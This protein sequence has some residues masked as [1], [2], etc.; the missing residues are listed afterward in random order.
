MIGMQN[1]SIKPQIK[2]RFLKSQRGASAVEFALVA[3]IFLMMMMSTFEV[4]WFYFVNSTLDTAITDISRKIR[5]GQVQGGPGFDKDDFFNDTVCPSLSFFGDCHQIAT[6]EVK[7]FNSFSELYDDENLSSGGD[8][9][10]CRGDDPEAVNNIP[11]D[12][13]TENSIVRVRLCIIYRTLNPA[14]GIN[15][16]QNANGERQL[17]S[18]FIFRNE[19][20][21]RNV[22]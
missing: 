20:F 21:L 8:P 19:P 13:G 9:I 15:L 1:A 14:V 10:I 5:T 12:P 4:G 22:N 7:V 17:T 6:A 11:V 18:T 2:N 16:K 3:P